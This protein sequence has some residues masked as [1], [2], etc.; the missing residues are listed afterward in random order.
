M[1]QLIKYFVRGMLA[2]VPIALT[3][4][5]LYWVVAAFDQLVGV[6]IPGLGLLVTIALITA[7]GFLVSNVIGRRVIGVFETLLSKVPLV[8][9]VYGSLK[10][11]LQAFVGQ[12]QSFG[13]PV[14][15]KLEDDSEACFFGFLTREELSM[16][17]LPSHVAVYV[18][19]AYNIGGQVIAVPRNRVTVLD[20]PTSELLTFV[21]SGGA[22]GMGR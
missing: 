22:S 20:I 21:M 18:P 19:Q 6:S 4:Y 16:A 10:D 13:Q 14:S 7:V 5:S 9:L 1:N 12:K 17:Q 8:K 11:V 2:V 3:L 15:I